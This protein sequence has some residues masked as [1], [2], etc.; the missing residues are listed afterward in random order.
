MPLLSLTQPLLNGLLTALPF[1]PDC[2]EHEATAFSAD[3]AV[4]WK[5]PKESLWDR[6]TLKS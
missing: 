2:S 6:K 5:A 4:K 3:G 1:S